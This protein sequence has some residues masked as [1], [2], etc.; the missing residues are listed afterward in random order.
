MKSYFL[1]GLSDR[2]KVRVAL[3]DRLPHWIEPWRLNDD[4]G[5]VIAFLTLEQGDE[6]TVSLQADLSGRHYDESEKVV[7]LLRQLQS[8][9]GGQVP[10]DVDN[11]L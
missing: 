5:D 4:A 9:L 11:V 7:G 3:S 1:E 2:Q 10:D 8:T 6:G